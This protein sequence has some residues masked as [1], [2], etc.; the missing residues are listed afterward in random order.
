[1]QVVSG[2]SKE[3][4]YVYNWLLTGCVLIAM[5]V[6]IG[7]ITRLTQSGLSMVKWEPIVGMI[8][9]LSQQD[10]LEVFELYKQSP[11]FEYF[12]SDF[13]LAEF[14]SIFFWEYL[15][16]LIARLL[17]FVF[18]IPCIVF[19][20]RGY[21]SSKLKK[22]VLLIFALGAFQGIL[23]WFMVKSGLVDQPHVSHY[24]LASHLITALGLLI[25]IYWVALSVKYEVTTHDAKKLRRPLILLIG[26]VA[27]Q[28]I[29][30]AFVAGLKAG[31]FYTT[32]PKMGNEWVPSIFDEIIGREG[33]ISLMENPGI[34]QFIHRI[35]ALVIVAIVSFL[36]YRARKL[37]L[38]IH[39]K[40]GLNS[41]LAAIAI[42]FTLGVFALI[43][44]VPIILGVFHQF[45]AIFVLLASFYLLF[46]LK[47]IESS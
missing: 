45:G 6:I 1:M 38:T 34:V 3:K 18:L 16:R 4:K 15:H 23:G 11:E 2:Y 5:I 42:Q 29:Y 12:N 35:C 32:W 44:A 36:W 19:W 39:Q 14:K 43:N 13:S 27:F 28:I 20:R 30:G 8:P 7:G 17:G 9:P 31:L 10:W 26:A 33:I 41:L 37:Q 21:F 24:R 25:Y 46:A 40:F 47:R 22:Q